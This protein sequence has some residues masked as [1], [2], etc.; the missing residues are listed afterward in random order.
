MFPNTGR[1]LEVQDEMEG[2][3]EAHQR[4]HATGCSE[5]ERRLLYGIQQEIER[6][7]K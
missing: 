6:Y 4:D 2:L 1:E 5:P 7:R 3:Y